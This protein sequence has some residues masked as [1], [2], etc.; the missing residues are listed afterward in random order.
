MVWRLASCEVAARNVRKCASNVAA[1][2][3]RLKARARP[4][5]LTASTAK[6]RG[7]LRVAIV[8][9]V[10]WPCAL[11]LCIAIWRAP[12]HMR[13]HTTPYPQP[14]AL[15]PAPYALRPTPSAHPPPTATHS[16]SGPAGMYT[17]R[18]LLRKV[19]DVEVDVIEMLPTPFGLVRYGEGRGAGRVAQS[20][21][22]PLCTCAPQLHP[23]T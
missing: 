19:E 5:S 10:A 14:C 23:K 6:A 21:S 8:G 15:C 7:P 17:A 12:E 3:G 4:L 9:E 16:G 18:T 2:G 13:V 11:N 1:R 20:A 22:S